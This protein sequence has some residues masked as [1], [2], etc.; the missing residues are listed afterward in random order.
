MWLHGL[1]R[2]S[3]A[4]DDLIALPLSLSMPMPFR[5][6]LAPAHWPQAQVAPV[7][8]AGGGAPVGLLDE[9]ALARLHELDPQGRAGLVQRV[10]ATYTLSLQRLL[11]Q[12]RDA[13]AAADR[14]GLRHAT[15]TLKSS[16]ASVG[17]LA[18]STLCAKVEA[19]VRE[20]G[21]PDAAALAV[22]LDKLLAE[23]ERILDGLRTS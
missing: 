14:E 18:L 8:T 15:H 5:R 12:L 19:Q 16:S 9:Q 10:L 7:A 17:A 11:E 20:A 13:R 2:Q 23:G 22:D 4:A 21:I 6:Q 3:I 1:E